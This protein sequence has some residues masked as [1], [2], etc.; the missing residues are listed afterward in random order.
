M[1]RRRNTRNNKG[2]A[3]LLHLNKKR[4]QIFHLSLKALIGKG[5]TTVDYPKGSVS[6]SIPRF[7]YLLTSLVHLVT[8]PISFPKSK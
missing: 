2:Y 1:T 5:E 6:N 7:Y 4:Q 8:K 3:S